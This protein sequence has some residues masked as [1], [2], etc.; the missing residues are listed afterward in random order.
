MVDLIRSDILEGTL[1]GALPPEFALIDRYGGTRNAIRDALGQL[2]DLG[3]VTRLPRTGTQVS[4]DTVTFSLD[5]IN[6]PIQIDETAAGDIEQHRLINL[7][8]RPAPEVVARRL[9][10]GLGDEVGYLETANSVRGV[11]LRLRASWVPAQRWRDLLGVQDLAGYLPDLVSAATG[12]PAKTQR[13]LMQALASD[14]RTAE[15]LEMPPG[16]AVFIL[17]RLMVLPDGS[18][19]EFGFSRIRGDRTVFDSRLAAG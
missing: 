15:L 5:R 13:M 10:I 6:V 1:S 16:T 19:I 3:L 8:Y 17:E 2:R 4:A 14:E 11:P 7:Q 18:P 9:G 12:Q